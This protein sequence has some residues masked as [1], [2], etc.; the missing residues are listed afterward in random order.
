MAGEN[1][2]DRSFI[3]RGEAVE[4]LHHRLSDVRAGSGAVTLLVGEAGVGKSTLVAEFL[5][6][7]RG[8]GVR[9]LMGRAPA[10]DD[11]PPFALLQSAIDSAR[12]DPLLRSDDDPLMGG[13]GLLIG[14]V[15]GMSEADLSAPVGIEARLTEVL[16]GV[17]QRDTRAREEVLT[18]ISRRLLELTRHG[19]TALLLEDIHH[20]DTPSLSAV[21]FFAKELRNRPLWILATLR[22]ATSLSS[23][24]KA[25]VEQFE[26]ATRA[27]RVI[28]RPMTLVETA[29]YLRRIDPSQAL[30]AQ[31]LARRHSET[32]GNPH[33]L[34][35]LERHE[36]FRGEP[37][38][39]EES[40][41]SRD[42][43]VDGTEQQ[44][45]ETAAVLGPEFPFDLLLAASHQDEER[46]TEEID[47]LV[48][49]GLLY[50]RPGEL[51]GFPDDRLRE[52]VYARLNEG[53]RR[54]LHR[55]AGEA[56]EAAG[57][58]DAS[59]IYALARHFYLGREAQRSVQYNRRAAEI[60]ERALTPEAAW[61]YFSHAIDSQ[62]AA[63][64]PDLDV[65][66]ELVLG[67]ARV[68]EELGVLQDAEEILRDF[69][70]RTQGGTPLAPARRATLEVFLA[71]V[72]TS[73]GN[74]PAAAEIAGRVL[75][76]PGLDD[77]W[78]VRVGALH[79]LGMVRYYE[80]RYAEALA[81]HTEEIE[82]ARRIGNP[83]ILARA[84]IW[85]VANLAML[86]QTEQAI[87]EAREVTAARDQL[88]SVR[89]S[90]QA[91]L[92]LGDIL[93]DARSPPA[94]RAEAI[95]EYAKVIRF[96]ELAKD[97]RRLG[98]ALYKTTELLRE[99][100]KLDEAAETVRSACHVLDQVG[101]H[102]GLSVSIK[103]RGQIAMDR[104]DLD[105]ADADLRE[106]LRLLQGTH[107]MTEEIDVVLRLTQLCLAR[108]DREEAQHHAAELEEMELPRIRPDLV[109]EFDA[110]QQALSPA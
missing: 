40:G 51:L 107:H 57:T 10:L 43:A 27:E 3:G 13:G 56:L 109:A 30:S 22:P 77:E 110:V 12:D 94:D 87:A 72:L 95:G 68:T 16:A 97:P 83:L 14:F 28:L 34:R 5:R 69:L 74:L 46:L 63:S 9:V 33:L 73:Q 47:E 64:A 29:D 88:G 38:A 92:F 59:R 80:G 71:R 104:G 105:R 32:G 41:E 96:A 82:L 31:E 70:D 42:V 108:G 50:E 21:E 20:A 8:R 76:A 36:L 91:H 55:R 58:E 4:A 101:D 90:A 62:R 67:W 100:G 103:V 1:G 19:P 24:G 39:S 84:Q 7:I 53:R 35:Q 17:E 45:L 66:A 93:A 89:E 54:F 15:P 2:S 23:S 106:A 49:R 25:R 75:G 81:H 102:V 11:P 44:I 18:E 79:H 37:G 65:E 61:E 99:A 78:L 86:G 52:Q 85:R 6:E 98:W 26:E 60:A 48:G